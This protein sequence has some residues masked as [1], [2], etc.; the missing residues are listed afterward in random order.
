MFYLLLIDRWPLDFI[1]GYFGYCK[2]LCLYFVLKTTI[3]SKCI[4][5]NIKC[6]CVKLEFLT[7]FHHYSIIY[8]IPN[9]HRSTQELKVSKT[10]VK[11]SKNAPSI[12]HL[13]IV[14]KIKKINRCLAHM[15]VLKKVCSEFILTTPQRLLVSPKPNILLNDW[16]YLF[17]K[18][19]MIWPVATYTL[20]NKKDNHL[21]YSYLQPL[22][23]ISWN[24]RYHNITS[25]MLI[26]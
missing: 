21:G 24:V 26:T 11:S 13:I 18:K 6:I 17:A 16:C 1:D 20:L 2:S 10:Q 12:V 4:S 8:F 3:D 19:V 15:K 22:I 25:F 14:F 23:V 5:P 7:V 9:K